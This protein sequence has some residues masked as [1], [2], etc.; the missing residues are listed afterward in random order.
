MV[1]STEQYIKRA[2]SQRSRLAALAGAR[3]SILLECRAHN[4]GGERLEYVMQLVESCEAADVA[5]VV[6]SRCVRHCYVPPRWVG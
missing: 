2:L 1:R 3:Q 5:H 6:A 4:T